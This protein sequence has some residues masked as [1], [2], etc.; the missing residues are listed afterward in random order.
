V[1]LVHGD[2][3]LEHHVPGSGG[4]LL[5]G[6]FLLAGIGLVV[7]YRWRGFDP[8][9]TFVLFGLILAPLPGAI[10]GPRFSATRLVTVPLFV[11]PFAI[12]G[13]DWL[14]RRRRPLAFGVAAVLLALTAGQIGF[15]LGV[16]WRDPSHRA[17]AYHVNYPSLLDAVLAQP[18]RPIFLVDRLPAATQYIHGLWYG[19][20]RKVPRGTL[21]RVRRGQTLPPGAIYLDEPDCRGQIQFA[22][23]N[24]FVAC[25]EK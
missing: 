19:E 3:I 17:V 12:A 10:G 8:W 20:L 24:E 13:L 2:R 23:A 11:M 18:R 9:W 16:Y 5:L 14:L 15:F 22:R 4:M 7:L 1:L 25:I 21:V 6:S